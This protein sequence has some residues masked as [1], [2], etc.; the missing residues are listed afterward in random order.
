MQ[1][2]KRSY[3]R[4][5]GLRQI[6]FERGRQQ[7]AP[8]IRRELVSAPVRDQRDLA[9]FSRMLL[10]PLHRRN[11]GFIVVSYRVVECQLESALGRLGRG[12]DAIFEIAPTLGFARA[13]APKPLQLLRR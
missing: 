4:W 1:R 11:S 6:R 7:L 13:L 12:V 10:R 9:R 2:I 5:P 3:G 8:F